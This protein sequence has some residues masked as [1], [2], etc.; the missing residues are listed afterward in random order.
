MPTVKFI[1]DVDGSLQW[2]TTNMNQ[3]IPDNAI[4][5]SENVYKIP[6]VEPEPEP[7]PDPVPSVLSVTDFKAFFTLAERIVI[8]E[9]GD[10]GVGII[11][12]DIEDPR[13]TS[14]DLGAPSTIEAIDHLATAGVITEARATELKAQ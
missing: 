6:V 1:S 5:V 3:I 14:V 9:S 7:E 12:N 2:Q 8:A 13:T 10:V 4:K 11:W